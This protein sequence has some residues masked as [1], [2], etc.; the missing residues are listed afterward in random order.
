MKSSVLKRS[1]IIAGHKTSVSLEDEFWN[2]LKQIAGGGRPSEE[3]RLPTTRHGHYANPRPAPL[4]PQKR[5]EVF[6]KH[7]SWS[8]QCRI[9]EPAGILRKNVGA[10]ARGKVPR[11]QP[12]SRFAV[13]G[14]LLLTA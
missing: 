7:V 9:A 12:L 1:I 6:D 14:R 8:S 10:P 5:L 11:R 4:Q 13:E 2:G 3:A